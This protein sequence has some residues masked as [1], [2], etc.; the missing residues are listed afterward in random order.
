M[1]PHIFFTYPETSGKTLEEIDTIFDNN[2]APWRSKSAGGHLD[3]RVAEL[4][5]AG[6]RK[7]S[8]TVSKEEHA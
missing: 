4:S 2:V 6:P 3:A 5:S 1:V 7:E 8:V